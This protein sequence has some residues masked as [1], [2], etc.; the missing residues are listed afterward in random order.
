MNQS[1]YRRIKYI[2]ALFLSM[3]LICSSCSSREQGE[4]EESSKGMLKNP[5]ILETGGISVSGNGGNDIPSGY[6][7]YT[8]AFAGLSIPYPKDWKIQVNEPN[9]IFLYNDSN[10]ILIHH[11]LLSSKENRI[12]DYKDFLSG[13]D[14]LLKEE[15]FS[16]FGYNNLQRRETQSLSS[17]SVINDDPDNMLIREKYDEA[18]MRNDEG[19]YV[20]GEFSEVRYYLR[21]GGTDTLISLFGS[22]ENVIDNMVKNI[23]TCK[24]A[25]DDVKPV[26]IKKASL[27]LPG[28]FE[29]K[30]TDAISYYASNDPGDAFAGCFAAEISDDKQI[31][32]PERLNELLQNIY[33]GSA[34]DNAY[35]SADTIVFDTGR[36][37]SCTI[38]NS[39][40]F[41]RTGTTWHLEIDDTES[42]IIGFPAVKEDLVRAFLEKTEDI[43]F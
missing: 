3:L 10:I 27:I 34:F 7:V 14:S 18:K 23:S 40:I 28:T 37:Y 35:D 41:P 15:T 43:S 30:E 8:D 1:V 5:I 12:R 20:S 4:I 16:F 11:N 29:K 24:I 21:S 33:P 36:A 38:D 9:Y 32:S 13:F 6:S 22:D 19:L 25:C 39:Y 31:Q 2:T 42:V 26:H 17:I